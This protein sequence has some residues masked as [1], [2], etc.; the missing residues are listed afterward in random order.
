MQ[1][2]GPCSG[3]ENGF[4]GEVFFFSAEVSFTLPQKESGKRSLA[5]KVTKKP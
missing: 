3:L 1:K 5:K 2:S 4:F